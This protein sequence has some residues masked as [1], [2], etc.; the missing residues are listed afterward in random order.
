MVQ[1]IQSVMDSLKAKKSSVIIGNEDVALTSSAAC[2]ATI[3]SSSSINDPLSRSFDYFTSIPS[4]LAELPRE[5]L[6]RLRAVSFTRPDKLIMCEVC[7]MANGFTTASRLSKLILRLQVLCETFISS[8]TLS[9]NQMENFPLRVAKG[10]SWS[11][12][13]LK[14]IINNAANHLYENC[15]EDKMQSSD[16]INVLD[17]NSSIEDSQIIDEG[18]YLRIYAFAISSLL[19]KIRGFFACSRGLYSGQIH[20]A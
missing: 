18:L 20:D 16:D 19:T 17:V 13:C 9:N 3:T 11:S 6:Q 15:F 1:L 14:K 4:D 7:L 10:F 2:F 5:L 12:V 8:Y